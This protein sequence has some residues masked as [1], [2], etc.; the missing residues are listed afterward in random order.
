MRI[1]LQN[2]N[3]QKE[4]M[5]ENSPVSSSIT[6]HNFDDSNC[7]TDLDNAILLCNLMQSVQQP[8]SAGSFIS[9][10]S[11]NALLA[12]ASHSALLQSGN[13]HYLELYSECMRLKTERYVFIDFPG[14]LS[15]L[16]RL[17]SNPP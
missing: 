9:T 4:Y 13:P 8:S 14:Q 12:S 17:C 15:C 7:G 2:L 1:V 3:L 10:I 11:A 5:Q 16:P 6:N